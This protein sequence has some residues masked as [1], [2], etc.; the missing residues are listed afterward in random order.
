MLLTH[1][2]HDSHKIFY[3]SYTWVILSHLCFLTS[4]HFVQT[5]RVWEENWLCDWHGTGVEN[6][7]LYKDKHFNFEIQTLIRWPIW[8][9]ET[10]NQ[11]QWRLNK[12]FVSMAMKDM[13]ES[14][15]FCGVLATCPITASRKHLL[16]GLI[17]K[18]D[19]ASPR[20]NVWASPL[21]NMFSSPNFLCLRIVSTLRLLEKAFF[22]LFKDLCYLPLSLCLGYKVVGWSSS[23]PLPLLSQGRCWLWPSAP[24]VL[25]TLGLLTST[26]SL[27]PAARQSGLLT[28]IHIFKFERDGEEKRERE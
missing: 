7:S 3:K 19:L 8:L 6:L 25:W 1:H 11:R 18:S 14:Y 21:T 22:I 12:A 15:P 27:I 23:A 9:L 20:L 10:Y 2:Q 13:S 28:F 26:L 4:F 17:V 5:N 24:T 16:K